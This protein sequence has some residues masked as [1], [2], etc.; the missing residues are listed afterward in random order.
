MDGLFRHSLPSGLH[1]GVDHLKDAL[2]SMGLG[3][4]KKWEDIAEYGIFVSD[5]FEQ[6]TLAFSSKENVQ[7]FKKVNDLISSHLEYFPKNAED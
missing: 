6:S 4:D 1:V 7:N 5:L 2:K 3:S